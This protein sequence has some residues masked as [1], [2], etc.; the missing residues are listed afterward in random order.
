MM[1]RC[2]FCSRALPS[3]IETVAIRSAVEALA[4]EADYVARAREIAAE[5]AA[6]PN[7]A[8]VAATLAESV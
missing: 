2:G 5:I 4:S 1:L 6:M 8:A 3:E 7:T